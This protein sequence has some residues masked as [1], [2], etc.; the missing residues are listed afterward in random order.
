MRILTIVIAALVVLPALADEPK[1]PVNACANGG[2]EMVIGAGEDTEAKVWFGGNPGD[3]P[4]LTAVA[5]T[6]KH[7]GRLV[8]KNEK[9]AWLNHPCV[10]RS[11]VFHFWYRAE[12]SAVRGKNLA[13]YLIPMRGKIGKAGNKEI[14]VVGGAGNRLPYRVPAEHVADGKWHEAAA[15]FDFVGLGADFVMVS[16]RINEFTPET[17]AGELLIDD[18]EVFPDP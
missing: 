6:G 9:T 4:L 10:A 12:K 11:G 5:H 14:D 13:I 7:A 16:P 2:F 18:V 3:E 1:K 15:E 17:G 8:A